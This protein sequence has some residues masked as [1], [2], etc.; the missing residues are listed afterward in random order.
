MKKNLLLATA[1]AL[2]FAVPAAAQVSPGGVGSKAGAQQAQATKSDQDFARK[3]AIGGLFE[4]ESSELANDKAQSAD[5]KEFAAQMIR[6][7][8]KAN[9][10][11]KSAAQELNI[12]LP[13]ELDSKHQQTLQKLESAQQGAA[14]DRAYI[15][16]QRQAHSEA[17]ALFSKHGKAN[18]ALSAWAQKTLP[19]LQQHQRHIQQIGGV[20]SKQQAPSDTGRSAAEPAAR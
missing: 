7:H 2:A 16:A 10:E 18:G 13:G 5:V 6:D 20:A 9:S 19:V 8:G 15:D 11:L 14:F 17:V 4:V 1:A 12:Q 3:A